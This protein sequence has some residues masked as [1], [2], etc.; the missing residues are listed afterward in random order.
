MVLKFLNSFEIYSSTEL[1]QG[2]VK[3]SCL[4]LLSSSF[5]S[6]LIFPPSSLFFLQVT[7]LILMCDS[8][9]LS[10]V[11]SETKSKN[12]FLLCMY[13]IKLQPLLVNL[14][15]AFAVIILIN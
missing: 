4:Q 14:A 12:Y 5:F 9:P 13:F 7:K 8:L 11:I 2:R 3:K 6:S 15:T 10:L 1:K